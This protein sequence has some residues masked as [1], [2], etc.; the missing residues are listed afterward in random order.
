MSTRRK[1]PDEGYGVVRTATR[2]IADLYSTLH[3]LEK[4]FHE[5]SAE[6]A[7]PS[8][9]LGMTKERATVP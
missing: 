6:T 1:R 9:S 7:G 4:R 3:S 5:R 8:A 2:K